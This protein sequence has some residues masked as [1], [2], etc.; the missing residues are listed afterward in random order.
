MSPPHKNKSHMSC[1]DLSSCSDCVAPIP[2]VFPHIAFNASTFNETIHSCLWCYLESNENGYCTDRPPGNVTRLC[3]GELMPYEIS[4]P[5]GG[6]NPLDWLVLYLVAALFIL[7]LIGSLLVH[8]YIRS[9]KIDNKIQKM[10][11]MYD[12]F[13]LRLV[14]LFN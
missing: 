7:A 1:S 5:D 9:L 4:C 14:H 8:C 10:R 12:V 3:P 2:R 6:T 13:A 11:E